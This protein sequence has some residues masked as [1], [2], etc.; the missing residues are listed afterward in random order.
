MELF[1]SQKEEIKQNRFPSKMGHF[2]K[3]QA[4]RSLALGFAS[5][6]GIISTV[7]RRNLTEGSLKKWDIF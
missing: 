5:L 6:G 1:S 2:T 4:T 7:K 3:I